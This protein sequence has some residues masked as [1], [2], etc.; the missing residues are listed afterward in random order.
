MVSQDDD[1]ATSYDG[2]DSSASACASITPSPKADWGGLFDSLGVSDR[3]AVIAHIR[4]LLALPERK[5]QAILAL[6]E[7]R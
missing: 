6:T 5:R 1:R 3:E 7:D 2:D 4:A